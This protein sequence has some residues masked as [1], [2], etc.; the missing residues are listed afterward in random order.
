MMK[1]EIGGMTVPMMGLGCMGMSTAYGRRDDAASTATVHRAL[2]LGVT[3]I[4]TAG[5]YGEGHNE[6]LL[7]AALKGRRDGVTLATKFGNR[8]MPDGS[9]V[10]CGRPDWVRAA[11]EASLSRLGTE[12]IDLYYLHRV[13]PEVP[14]EE[15]VGA[16]ADLVAEGKVRHLGLSEAGAATIARAHAT[17]PIAALQSEYSLWTREV[18]AEIL[19]LCRRLG[20]G[21]VAYSPLGRGFLTGTVRGREGLAESDRRRVHPRFAP[22]NLARNASMLTVLE[23]EAA[24]L[25]ASPAQL[26]LAWVLTRGQDVVPIP[27]T[28]RVRWL[29]ENLAALD[30]ALDA[31][32]LATLEAAFPPGATAGSR[33][34][35]PEMDRLG[36]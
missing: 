34:P 19:P 20:I 6:T 18:E 27:G 13:D 5:I 9:R 12:A 28:K 16:M 36:L 11:C 31:Q 8:V 26:A 10:I 17:H 15:T 3:F 35:E 2:E 21:F 1:R 7:G 14:I 25:A 30:L 23:T 32:A 24:R 4:D 29:E 33:Y 22:E